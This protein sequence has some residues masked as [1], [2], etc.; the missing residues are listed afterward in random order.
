VLKHS[1][2]HGRFELPIDV[3][4]WSI[5]GQ[6]LIDGDPDVL[7]RYDGIGER[8]EHQP[9][10]PDQPT[11]TVINAGSSV[12]VSKYTASMEPIFEPSRSRT[13]LSTQSVMLPTVIMS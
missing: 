5:F 11:F 1:G 2:L 10:R 12:D 7:G 9:S 13:G 6:L 4:G 3:N 8:N